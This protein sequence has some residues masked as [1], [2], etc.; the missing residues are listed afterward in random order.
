MGGINAENAR[1]V[2]RI[3]NDV[4]MN[5]AAAIATVPLDESA[6]GATASN[7]LQTIMQGAYNK[8]YAKNDLTALSHVRDATNSGSSSDEGSLQLPLFKYQVTYDDGS[9]GL[10]QQV[11]FDLHSADFGGFAAG[12][13]ASGS[14]YRSAVLRSSKSPAVVVRALNEYNDALDKLKGKLRKFTNC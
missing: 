6:I 13:T 3:I 2:I 8:I 5:T 4:M 11:M 7:N 9:T 12:K 1:I 14:A 10:T